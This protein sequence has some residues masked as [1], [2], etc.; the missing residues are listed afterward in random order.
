MGG[1]GFVSSFAHALF[2]LDLFFS[3]SYFVFRGSCFLPSSLIVIPP[4]FLAPVDWDHVEVQR[5]RELIEK[6]VASCA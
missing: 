3:L 6:E 1:F 2:H 5:L 4:F